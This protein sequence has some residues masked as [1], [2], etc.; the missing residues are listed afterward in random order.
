MGHRQFGVQCRRFPEWSIVVT[1][2]LTLTVG[3]LGVIIFS[4]LLLTG[5]GEVVMSIP[6]VGACMATLAGMMLHWFSKK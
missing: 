1:K 4:P 6:F 3:V 2:V 5:L